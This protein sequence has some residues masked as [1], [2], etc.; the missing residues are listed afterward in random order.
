MRDDKVESFWSKV[1]K[2]G[3]DECWLWTGCIQRNG[4]GATTNVVGS[5][6][7]HRTAWL[8]A[9]PGVTVTRADV[10][11]HTCDNRRCCN[12]AHLRCGTYRENS[13]DMVAKGRSRHGEKHYLTTLTDL[14]VLEIAAQCG[15]GFFSRREI[16]AHWGVTTHWLARLMRGAVWGHVTGIT[17]TTLES[18]LVSNCPRCG[19]EVVRRTLHAKRYCSQN[20]QQVHWKQRQ[21][22][23]WKAKQ[24]EAQ[25][26]RRQKASE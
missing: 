25:V 20:C 1:A 2:G 21:G 24:N 26:K 19:R 22:T 9:H 3:D 16:A 15:E 12:P 17:L 10:V 7:A 5:T 14:D 4:Y 18:P 6:L 23:E 13:E 11:R 8:L